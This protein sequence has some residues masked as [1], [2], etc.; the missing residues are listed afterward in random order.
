[1]KLIGRPLFDG[2]AKSLMKEMAVGISVASP[3]PTKIRDT[4]IASKLL[5]KPP[6]TVAK[7]QQIMP[8]TAIALREYRSARNPIGTAQ[9][10]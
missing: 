4:N 2:A 8:H 5:V 10:A 1:M 3:N 6:Q 7:L 9:V